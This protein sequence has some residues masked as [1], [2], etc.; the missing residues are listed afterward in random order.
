MDYEALARKAG[1]ETANGLR[2]LRWV[3]NHFYWKPRR[4]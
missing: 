1:F 2:I 3:A 4:R